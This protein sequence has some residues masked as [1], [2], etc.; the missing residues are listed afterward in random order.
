MS[1][2][3]DAAIA[4]LTAECKGKD[5]LIPFEEYLTSICTT[6]A[7]ADKILDDKKEL[8]KCFEFS[9]DRFKKKAVK[10]CAMVEDEEAYEVIRE[11]YGIKLTESKLAPADEVVDILDLI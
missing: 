6:D 10:G 11:Y 4:K 3:T 5:Y 8:E 2:K 9:K 7:V 1:T